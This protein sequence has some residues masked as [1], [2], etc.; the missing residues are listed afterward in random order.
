M[1]NPE[2]AEVIFLEVDVD[3]NGVGT[4]LGYVLQVIWQKND[5][6]I[7]LEF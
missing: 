6:L 7:N 3:E 5:I 4:L 2:F 1:S